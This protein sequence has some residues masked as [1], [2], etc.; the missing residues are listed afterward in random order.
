MKNERRTAIITNDRRTLKQSTQFNALTKI[1]QSNETTAPTK[2]EKSV[3]AIKISTSNSSLSYHIFSFS[4]KKQWLENGF[5]S[6]FV[7]LTTLT[8]GILMVCV[9]FSY[10]TSVESFV[11]EPKWRIIRLS[12][13][14]PFRWYNYWCCSMNWCK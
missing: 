10:G 3:F 9:L 6:V 12:N 1:E 2:R 4:L 5:D 8:N 7:Q 13:A 14:H 11:K